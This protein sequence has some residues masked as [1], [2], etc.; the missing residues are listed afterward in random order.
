MKIT[1]LETIHV[2]P[3]WLF[4][5]VHTDEGIV[6]Y[7]EPVVEGRARTVAT[8]ISEFND[9]LVGKNPLDIE[10]L[11]QAM[12]RNVYYRSGPVLTSALSG[13][14]QALWDIK[15]KYYNIPVY[16]MLG[17]KC[18]DR[19]RMYGHCW[20]A[21][22]EKIIHRALA[23]KERGFDAIKI[24][25]E[26][27]MENGG[28]MKYIEG[29]INRFAEIRE[30]IGD[31]MDLAID[32]HGRVDPATAIQIINGIEEY[33]PMFVEEACLPEN[34]DA[35]IKISQKTNVAIATGERLFTKWGF[36]TLLENQAVDILQPDLCHVGGIFETK[37]IAA[38]AEV[39]YAKIAPHNPLGPISLAANLQVA[40]CTPNF[41]IQ[42]HFGMKEKWDLGEGY[43]KEPFK[44]DDGYITVDLTKPGLGIVLNDDVV[45]QRTFE[46]N[47]DSPRLFN[48]DDNSIVD[49]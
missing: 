5:K 43:L 44:I 24:L 25:I 32:F 1:K 10:N 8:A 36:K 31:D 46:G 33:R 47:W 48:E 11:W 6:G 29:Q 39:N 40:M 49:W 4:L 15:G 38:M 23:R 41:L 42:E 19:I 13:I 7:G 3:R 2:K 45:A 9:F 16:E 30:A 28:H 18:R 34:I 21:T 20:G 17:G 12:Y 26:P 22:T 37:K 14:E 27:K 35:M